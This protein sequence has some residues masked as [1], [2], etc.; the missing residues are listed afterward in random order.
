MQL[1]MRVMTESNDLLRYHL[2]ILISAIWLTHSFISYYSITAS[3]PVNVCAS[4]HHCTG[5]VRSRACRTMI[6]LLSCFMFSVFLRRESAAHALSL[7][8][9]ETP[10]HNA[11]NDGNRCR[12][13]LLC[14]KFSLAFCAGYQTNDMQHIRLSGPLISVLRLFWVF[15]N[16]P[17][18]DSQTCWFILFICTNMDI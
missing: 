13:W 6:L 14:F 7:Q 15:N 17:H 10:R 11:P 12:N 16:V 5:P 2:L 4:M 8:W 9:S 1:K 3:N 18:N